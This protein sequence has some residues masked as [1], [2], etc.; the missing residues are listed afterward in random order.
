MAI[1]VPR[2]VP[3]NTPERISTWSAS[4]L[5]VVIALCPGRRRS[6]STCTACSLTGSPGGMPSTSTPTAG[7]CDSPNVL[8]RN[9]RPIV[10]DIRL[11]SLAP[12]PVRRRGRLAT[13][14][15]GHGRLARSRERGRARALAVGLVGQ[16]QLL[17]LR[18]VRGSKVGTR[19]RDQRLDPLP[20]DD[21]LARV[22]E[23][24]LGVERAAV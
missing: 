19:V 13:R 1:G 15:R 2:L 21:V 3:S 11:A 5:W 12:R 22:V 20:R 23:E 14:D 8:T 9:S 6:S 18:Q 17:E 7:P 4:F 24:Q 10:D 16:H